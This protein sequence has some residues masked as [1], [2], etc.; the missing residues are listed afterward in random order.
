MPMGQPTS[1]TK[2]TISLLL[3][4]ALTLSTATCWAVDLTVSVTFDDIFHWMLAAEDVLGT[5]SDD[6]LVV[7]L[8]ASDNHDGPVIAGLLKA[9]LSLDD[10][11]IQQEVA[12]EIAAFPSECQDM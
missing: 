6:R 2:R 12:A 9:D 5:T 4:A 8:D 10:P 1:V 7:L 3:T 11:V